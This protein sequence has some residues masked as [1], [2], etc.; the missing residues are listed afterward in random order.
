MI[1]QFL[2]NFL[3]KDYRKKYE[4]HQTPSFISKGK[5]NNQIL[6]AII[7]ENH[8]KKL[9]FSRIYVAHQEGFFY[10]S[11]TNS[12]FIYEWIELILS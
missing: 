10:Y 2:T 5:C 12:S 11:K 6:I 9:N 3:F 1:C 8:K 7:L 4:R